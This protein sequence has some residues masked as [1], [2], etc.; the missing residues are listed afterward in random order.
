[1]RLN[2][3]RELIE[4]GYEVDVVLVK[5]EGSYLDTVPEGVNIVSFRILTR[6]YFRTFFTLFP[7]LRYL[8]KERPEA[9]VS[10]LTRCNVVAAL[11]RV[12]SR[13]G[14]RVA[15][16]EHNNFSEATRSKKGIK[17]WFVLFFMKVLYPRV[18][19][20]IAVSKGV[21]DDL[22]EVLGM[23]RERI[24]VIYNP[25]V[26]S[27]ITERAREK[28]GVTWLNK[29]EFKTVIGIGR[30]SKAKNFPLL[31]RAFGQVARERDD[32]RLV[33]LGEGEEGSAIRTEI[34]KLGIEERVLLPGFVENPYAYLARAD[35]FVLSSD[36]E[37]FGNV[38]VEALAV[39][40]PVV[41]TDCPSGP[42]EILA[43]GE[44]GTLV[45]VGDE[46]MLAEAIRNTLDNLAGPRSERLIERAQEF[47]ATRSAKEYIRTV[48]N[49]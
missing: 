9:L 3:A 47:T 34:E 24:A 46:D 19:A 37:G 21:A 48:L 44:Y 25:V 32:A 23:E 8:K 2:L 28:T 11:A 5:K 42:R 14:A 7:L 26:T 43:D 45:P 1:M 10:S 20:V 15:V 35:V 38:I 22:A 18:D 6:K 4:L 39:G 40:T 33:L 16:V 17:Q 49:E 29:G 27:A 41:T 13:S 36:W 12:V 30:F 31:V